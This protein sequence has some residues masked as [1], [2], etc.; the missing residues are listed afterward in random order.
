MET[1]GERLRLARKNKGWSQPQLAERT[2]VNQAT[3]SKIERGDQDQSVHTPILAAALC[4][5][6][7]WLATGQG[8]SGQ[9]PMAIGE[10]V[11]EY[12][13]SRP[14]GMAPLISSV[15]AG[16]WCEAVDN[17]QPGDA[18]EWVPAPP[19]ASK[20]AYALR[21]TGSSMEP[22]FNEGEIV[23][24]DPE[25]PADSGKFVVAKKTGTQEVTLKQLIQE[26]G[27]SY[28]Q[29]LNPGWPDKIIRLSEEW[30]ICG[31]VICKLEMF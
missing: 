19:S 5:D 7:L 2:A 4:V 12:S 21:V 8:S 20:H 11:G 23:V 3:I 22:R 15:Q 1:F 16:S 25:K 28:L 6:A 13:I 27:E 14:L 18:D 31:V 17:F 24:I 26:G 30:L 29:A 9:H 10:A